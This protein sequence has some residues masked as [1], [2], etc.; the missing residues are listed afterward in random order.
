ML[1]AHPELVAEVPVDGANPDVDT[2]ADHARA[3]EAAWAAR[4]RANR[5]QVE[6]IREVPDGTDFYAPVNSLF[7]ADPTRTDDPVLDALLRLTR[8]GDTWLDIGAGAGRFALPI[9][10]SARPV[11]RRGD[12]ARCVALDARVAPRD[13]RGLRH[14]ERA[15]GRGALA[16]GRSRASRP[17]TSADV[18]LIA[19]VGYD[20]EAI[21]PFLDALEA[22]ATRQCVAV[23]MERVPAS[24]ADPFWPPVHG[25]AR[26]ALPALPDVLELLEAR[27]RHPEVQR[28]AVEPRRFA[29]RDAL[30]GFIRRQLWI[31]P[32]GKKE[33]RFQ[34]A[35]ET[36]TVDDG[37]GWTIAGR[38]PSDVGVVTWT[39]R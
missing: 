11:G 16:A 26:V 4:V 39:P 22:A 5:D 33:S 18:A 6:R 15:D 19:H 2:P 21:G 37:D 31:D 9:A 17:R 20:V 28:I 25:E 29:S 3:I 24:A 34:T 8:S 27:G 10:R 14:R 35:L 1:A 23:L 13:R 30:E 36:L 38:G 12:R 32:T 7:R